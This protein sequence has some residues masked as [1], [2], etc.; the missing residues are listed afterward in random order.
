MADPSVEAGLTELEAMLPDVRSG[1]SLCWGLLGL[2]AWGRRP[3]D[4]DH[5]LSEAAALINQRSTP[6]PE[7][8]YLLL[9][10]GS[11]SLQLLGL[12]QDETDRAAR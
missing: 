6:A 10:A 2:A 5:W 9:A 3:S 12:P 1:Q 8:A 7:L 11:H 4:A